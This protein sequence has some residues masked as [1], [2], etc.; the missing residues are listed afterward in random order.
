MTAAA[1]HRNA[2]LLAGQRDGDAPEGLGHV[3]AHRAQGNVQL[4]GNG[5]VG[6]AV[7][8]AQQKGLARLERQA[9]QR[10]GDVLQRLQQHGALFGRRRQ[11]LGLQGQGLQ[12]GPLQ[13][14]PAPQ[15][16]QQAL[17]N[18]GQKRARLLHHGSGARGHHAHKGLGRHILRLG[19]VAQPGLQTRQQPGMVAHIQLLDLEHGF[20]RRVRHGHG[21]VF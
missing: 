12:I 6:Q 8:L 1:R 7:D 17:G 4:V 2:G 14:A 16:E 11:L 5:L 19:R 13:L 9:V 18:G 21:A 15:R 3:A 20:W 10:L